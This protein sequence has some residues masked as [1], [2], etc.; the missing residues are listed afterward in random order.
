[1]LGAE[2]VHDITSMSIYVGLDVSDKTTHV[3][4][5]D[6][7]GKVLRRHV[8]AGC[9]SNVEARTGDRPLAGVARLQPCAAWTTPLPQSIRRKTCG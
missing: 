6:A 7:V 8:V 9:C 3:C 4:V 5:V 1:M 2:V